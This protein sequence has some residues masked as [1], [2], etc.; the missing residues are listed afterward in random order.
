M[1]FGRLLEPSR[2]VVD[3][4]TKCDVIFDT[5]HG[6]SVRIC[7]EPLGKLK[8]LILAKHPSFPPEIVGLFCK[9]KLFQG[10]KTSTIK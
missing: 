4:C 9:V 8:A 5:F 3:L 6:N 1:I 2:E 7:H 10:S